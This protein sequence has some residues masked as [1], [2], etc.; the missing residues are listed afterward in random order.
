LAQPEY[1]AEFAYD[2]TRKWL[3]A[4][5][6]D[7]KTLNHSGVFSTM[8]IS[9]ENLGLLA[10]FVHHDLAAF[11]QHWYLASRLNV[12]AEK[13][14]PESVSY[15]TGGY[16]S[17]AYDLIHALVSD[18]QDA[19][20]EAASLDTFRLRSYRNEPK[21]REF[22]FHLAQLVIRG[23]YESAQAKIALGAKKAGGKYKQAYAAGT[24]FYSLLMKGDKAALE[25]M[26]MND[27]RFKRTGYICDFI[28]PIAAFKAKFCWYKG[29]PVEIEHPKVPMEW[30][31]VEPL[32]RY[33]DIYDFFSPDWTPPDQ[34]LLARLKRKFQKTY[35]AVDACMARIRQIDAPGYSS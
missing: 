10:Y 29:I 8:E 33:E 25:T 4:L 24:D 31:P 6:D 1:W 17:G 3:T 30:M 16:V 26:I 35:P 12:L 22:E 34:S 9:H 20:N 28:S 32:A 2:N 5:E 13:H 11:K 23:D 7:Y 27:T 19:I 18:G 14:V 15:T 21:A